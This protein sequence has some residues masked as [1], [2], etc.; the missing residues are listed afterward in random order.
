MQELYTYAMP[1]ALIWVVVFAVLWVAVIA[2]SIV[3]MARM[4]KVDDKMQE[5]Q[6]LVDAKAG[7]K[8]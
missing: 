7:H 8:K 4:I 3:I 2:F 6:D 5:L 1:H